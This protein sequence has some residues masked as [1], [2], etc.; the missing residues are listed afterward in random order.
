MEVTRRIQVR[1][2]PSS[3]RPCLGLALLGRKTEET[4]SAAVG[5]VSGLTPR[6]QGR[7]YCVGGG[8]VVGSWWGVAQWA[9]RAG[10]PATIRRLAGGPL[11]RW[12]SP[13][14]NSKMDRSVGRLRYEAAKPNDIQ[15]DRQLLRIGWEGEGG[16]ETKKSKSTDRGVS[17]RPWATDGREAPFAPM[18]QRDSR[19]NCVGLLMARR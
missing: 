11:R 8:G 12:N 4:G 17:N 13:R 16:R 10:P 19:P 3:C 14:G 2:R 18:V 6:D 15:S 5:T 9:A 1:N 7:K